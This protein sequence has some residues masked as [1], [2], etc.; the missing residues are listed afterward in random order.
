MELENMESPTESLEEYDVVIMN[1]SIP[2]VVQED[3]IPLEDY[4]VLNIAS[5]G[6]HPYKRTHFPPIAAFA[7]THGWN[8][9]IATP[10]ACSELLR[11]YGAILK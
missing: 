4:A 5:L 7:K 9:L 3:L 11:K 2:L 10:T 8:T 6:G 1:D